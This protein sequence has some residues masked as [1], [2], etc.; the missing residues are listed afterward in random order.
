MPNLSEWSDS[1]DEHRK[2]DNPSEQQ[3]QGELPDHSPWIIDVVR[4]L[5]NFPAGEL[6]NML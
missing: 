6:E 4:Q 5:E 3:A 2:Y 1:L